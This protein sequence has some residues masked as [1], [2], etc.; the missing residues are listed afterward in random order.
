MLLLISLVVTVV[1]FILH[2]FIST[3][4][5]GTGVVLYEMIVHGEGSEVV[6]EIEHRTRCILEARSRS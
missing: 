3:V 2:R 4:N 1:Y 5:R 6:N